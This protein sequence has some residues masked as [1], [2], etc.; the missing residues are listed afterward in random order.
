MVLSTQRRRLGRPQATFL[1]LIP[2]LMASPVKAD[3]SAG[4]L[5]TWL[6]Y[7]T[8]GLLVVIIVYYCCRRA[9]FDENLQQPLLGGYVLA[10]IP[11]PS[12]VS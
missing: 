2:L 7:V 9:R 3:S 5:P 1:S 12:L 4:T 11:L 10:R 8:G 6:A